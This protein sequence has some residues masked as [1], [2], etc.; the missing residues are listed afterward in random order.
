MQPKVLELCN[1]NRFSRILLEDDDDHTNDAV[2]DD[3]G[4]GDGD[5]GGDDD[6]DDD[7]NDNDPVELFQKRGKWWELIVK[8]SSV[9]WRAVKEQQIKIEH[10]E[11]SVCELQESM[12]ELYN[13]A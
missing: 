5:G 12:K 10:L 7:D 11:A 9:L 8:L 6:D 3:D 4:D 1:L 2:D 13:E